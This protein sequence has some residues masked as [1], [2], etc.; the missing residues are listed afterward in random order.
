ML[1]I[2][3]V[4]MA[5]FAIVMMVVMLV[6][7]VVAMALF[8]IV[9]MVMLVVVIVAM[10]LL[11]M[12]MMVM[13][14]LGFYQSFQ[15]FLDGIAALHSG[16]QLLAI[17]LTPGG[18]NDH[19]GGVMLLNE[20]NRFFDLLFGCVVGVRK[21]NAACV[22]DLIVEELAE[23]THIHLAFVHVRNGGEAVQHRPLCGSILHGANNV[24]K[25]ADA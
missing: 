13:V 7:M 21:H 25:L 15:L 22:L 24:G 17:Q 2:M 9:M 5:L 3:V 18:G 11:A 8:A 16:K 1:V 19:R 6:I 20:S 12:V 4:A 23:V 10:T 14:C